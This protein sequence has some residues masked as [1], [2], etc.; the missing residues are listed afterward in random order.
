MTTTR[1][2]HWEDADGRR[3]ASLIPADMPDS[4]ARRGAVLGPP[5][6]SPLG[7][8]LAMEVRLHN[9]LHAG[10]LFTEDDFR[11]RGAEVTRAIQRAFRVD[12]QTMMAECFRVTP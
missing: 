4:E 8:P 2:A 9:E 1:I 3:Y 5:D 6:L 12:L 11:R 7:L 10:E